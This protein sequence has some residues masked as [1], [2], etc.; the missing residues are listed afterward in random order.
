MSEWLS[1]I[2]PQMT[3]VGEDVEKKEPSCTVGANANLGNSMAFPQKIKNRTDRKLRANRWLIS[4]KSLEYFWYPF[5]IQIQSGQIFMCSEIIMIWPLSVYCYFLYED[6][7]TVFQRVEG[8]K[9]NIYVSAGVGWGE[10]R[11]GGTKVGLQL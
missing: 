10:G 6:F 5:E 3:G 9:E 11:G 4:S 7:S 1:S 8:R 2:N